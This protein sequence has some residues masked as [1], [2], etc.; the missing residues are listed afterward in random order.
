MANKVINKLPTV[1]SHHVMGTRHAA[2]IASV[3]LQKC[4]LMLDH[5]QRCF[6]F[7][8]VQLPVSFRNGKPAFSCRNNPLAVWCFC[9]SFLCPSFLHFPTKMFHVEHTL[10]AHGMPP[11]TCFWIFLYS[12]KLSLHESAAEAALPFAIQILSLLC[13]SPISVPGW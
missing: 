10:F 4:P 1:F 12:T 6:D 13:V 9:L 2:H 5:C 11:A 7:G 3:T 8:A